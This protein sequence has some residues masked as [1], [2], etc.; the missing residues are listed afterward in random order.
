MKHK[1]TMTLDIP[2]QIVSFVS[3]TDQPPFFLKQPI[4]IIEIKNKNPDGPSFAER[5]MA[6]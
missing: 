4:S 5:G 1:E 2:F 3:T 6:Q